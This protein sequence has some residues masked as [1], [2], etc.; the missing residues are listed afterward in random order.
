MTTMAYGGK[1]RA[2]WRRDNELMVAAVGSGVKAMRDDV[3]WG[4]LFG[5]YRPKTLPRGEGVDQYESL[6]PPV[7]Q[8][9]QKDGSNILPAAILADYI[10]GPAVQEV[11]V[12]VMTV[13]RGRAYG[14]GQFGISRCRLMNAA[15]MDGAERAGA[16]R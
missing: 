7:D 15:Q 12:L 13:P 16:T 5:V 4:Y 9:I 14:L 10:D 2:D 8:G 3:R 11:A 6:A 1:S